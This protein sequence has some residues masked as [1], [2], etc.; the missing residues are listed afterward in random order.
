MSNT[1]F[2]IFDRTIQKTNKLLGKVEEEYD[3]QERREQS[4][5]AVREVLHALRDRLR[6]NDSANFASQ[7]P[8]LLQGVYFDGWDPANVPQKMTKEEFIN[9]IRSN[10][11]YSVE[12]GIPALIDI[13]LK[14]IFATMNPEIAEDIKQTLPEDLKTMIK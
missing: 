1:G 6:V 3:W 14:N 11:D 7:L 8:M 2:E 4:Y 13:V 12:E 10:F 9:R 5:S